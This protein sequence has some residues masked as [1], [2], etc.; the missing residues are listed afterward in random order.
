MYFGIILVSMVVLSVSAKY[1]I[2]SVLEIS[3][4]LGITSTIL[5]LSVVALGTS[6]PEV[7]ASMSAI[8]NGNHGIA[9]GNVF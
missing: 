2:D 7:F 1:F 9:I 8:R 5:T 6:L 3:S 4:Q